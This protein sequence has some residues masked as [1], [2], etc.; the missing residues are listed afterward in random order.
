VLRLLLA[1]ILRFTW[2]QLSWDQGYCLNADSSL[3]AAALIS[4]FEGSARHS[5]LTW[6]G[7]GL[8]DQPQF[9]ELCASEAI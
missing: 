2:I 7:F 9:A 5:G 4:G 8:D 6:V 3:A 1:G